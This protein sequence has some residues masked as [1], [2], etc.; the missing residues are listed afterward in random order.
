[1]IEEPAPPPEPVQVES[2]PAPPAPKRAPRR[3]H[4]PK[5]E[6]PTAPAEADSEAEPAEEPAAEVPPLQPRENSARETA[7]RREIQEMQGQVQQQI[8]RL[9]LTSLSAAERKSLDA[10]RTFLAQST[11]AFQEGDLQR[12]L[13]LAQKAALLVTALRQVH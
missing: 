6:G 1:V 10:A 7:Q 3:R 8:D 11:R 12:S 5:A 4:V 2:A 9:Q 13:I